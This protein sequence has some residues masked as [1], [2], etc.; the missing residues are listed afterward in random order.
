MS[1]LLAADLH[2]T[3]NPRDRHRLGI[4][5][6]LAETSLNEGCEE[7]VLLGDVTDAKDR[8][9]AR[10]VNWLCTEMFDL[11]EA[12]MTT[13]LRGN[14]DGVDPRW[15]FFRFL[16]RADRGVH[17][18]V[19][20]RIS[21]GALWLPNTADWQKD[22][23]D[24][25]PRLGEVRRVFTHVTFTGCLAENGTR[26]QGGVPPAVFQG[27]VGQVWSGDIHVPQRMGANIEYVGAPY[28]IRFGDTFSPRC[29]LLNDDGS[30]KNLRYPCPLKA[31]VTLRNLE[32]LDRYRLHKDDQV[33]IRVL[34]TRAEYQDW[35]QMRDSLR[36]HAEAK[37]WDVCGGIEL[38]AVDPVPQNNTAAAPVPATSPEDLVLAHGRQH[39]LDDELLAVGRSL[40]AAAND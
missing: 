31:L 12:T 4:L 40:I 21:R 36:Q 18:L 29:V 8:H 24:W 16:D 10:F 6:W 23:A 13:W 14:H 19:E 28:R 17:Y 25:L 9:S 37:G 33:K 34:L 15:P 3:D 38:V 20:P 11:G 5:H 7:V 32:D 27:F 35:P 39:Q 22:W 26:M 2:L 1:S 30:T